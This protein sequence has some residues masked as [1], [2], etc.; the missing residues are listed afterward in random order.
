MSE[1]PRPDEDT[2]DRP[3]ERPG[4]FRRD[5]EPGRGVPLRFQ[6]RCGLALALP[7]ACLPCSGVVTIPLALLLLAASWREVAR[8]D[9]GHV[10]PTD[11]DAASSAFGWAL[12]CL[13][14]S[15]INGVI[16]LLV[17]TSGGRPFWWQWW[18]W[19]F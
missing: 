19:P 3:W 6:A 1:P 13:A 18:Q 9:A 7:L 15:T 17:V 16:S 14:L 2:D 10:D 5:L 12:A 11:R 8:I 4:A